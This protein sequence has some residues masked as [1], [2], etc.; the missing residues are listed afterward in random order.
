MRFELVLASRARAG[1][2]LV[3]VTA[4][5]GFRQTEMGHLVLGFAGRLDEGLVAKLTLVKFFTS[6]G[7]LV[8]GF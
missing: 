4:L 5:V 3:A 7:G 6:V 2:P 1:E 8:V